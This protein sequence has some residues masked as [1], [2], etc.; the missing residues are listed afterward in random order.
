MSENGVP[1]I[2]SL[3]HSLDMQHVC[4]FHKMILIKMIYLFIPHALSKLGHYY[5]K[6]W[7]KHYQNAFS[8]S[9]R[10]VISSIGAIIG[11]KGFT[12]I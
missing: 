11:R 12:H 2:L 7:N 5:L 8:I 10:A 9:E 1:F 6:I 4:N 3:E